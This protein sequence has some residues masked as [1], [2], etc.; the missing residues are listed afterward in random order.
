MP[1]LPLGIPADDDCDV[2]RERLLAEK[3]V[4][5]EREDFATLADG[6]LGLE[7]QTPGE[8]GAKLGQRSGIENDARKKTTIATLIRCPH[9]AP[10]RGVRCV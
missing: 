7:R 8:F 5:C 10:S 9:S 1:N 4:A 3:L 2:R 6:K